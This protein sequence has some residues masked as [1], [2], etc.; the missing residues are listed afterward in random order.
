MMVWQRYERAIKKWWKSWRT[1]AK[2]VGYV[3]FQHSVCALSL[4]PFSVSSTPSTSLVIVS[5]S[6]VLPR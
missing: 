4:T 6:P 3:S 1:I 2:T 5:F